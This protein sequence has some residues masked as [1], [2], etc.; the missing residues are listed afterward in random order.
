[1]NLAKFKSIFLRIMIGCLVAAGMLAVVTVLTGQFNEVF[2]KSLFTILLIALHA[3]VSF[4]YIDISEK[5]TSV[6]DLTFFH[7]ATFVLIILSFITSIF[8]TW[9]IISS[10]LVVKLY[11]TYFVLLFAILHGEI[12]NQI[13]GNDK[14]MDKIVHSNY[15]FMVIVVLLI[16]PVIYSSD[17]SL[18]GDFY[19]RILAA[20]GIVDAILTLVAI[21]L[22]KL[23]LQKHPQVNSALFANVPEATSP[24]LGASQTSQP[25]R[26]PSILI[27]ILVGFLGVQLLG[28]LLFALIGNK[29]ASNIKNVNTDPSP[30]VQI[31][32]PTSSDY[33]YET[34][35]TYKDID[36]TCTKK[37]TGTWA[38]ESSAANAKNSF[39]FTPA[40]QN[41]LYDYCYPTD[42]IN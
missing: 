9:A 35:F 23:Y 7:N 19:Y 32:D 5:K 37:I 21:I 38:R 29:A 34:E 30:A 24:P 41:E 11:A 6:N 10:S 31:K 27:I 2:A 4:G 13:V 25:K 36:Y 28:S 39:S 18:L 40:N 42:T 17:A 16:L 1:M 12:L 20:F 3:L 26:G 33:S 15:L 14:T 22:N 8:G